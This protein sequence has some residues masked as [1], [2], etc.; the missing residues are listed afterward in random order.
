MGRDRA[1]VPSFLSRF[2]IARAKMNTPK[3][4]IDALSSVTSCVVDPPSADFAGDLSLGS[5]TLPSMEIHQPFGR[6]L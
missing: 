4:A 3:L 2:P 5:E 6:E 1:Q